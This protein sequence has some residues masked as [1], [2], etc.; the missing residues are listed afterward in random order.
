MNRGTTKALHNRSSLRRIGLAC[1]QL[2][3]G[4]YARMGF[5]A[6]GFV[7]P[8]K[9]PYLFHFPDGNASI[10]RMLVRSLIP[11]SAAGTTAEDI[12][13]ARVDYGK[14]DQSRSP[15]KIRLNSTVVR[16][17]HAGD[18]ASAKEVEVLYSAGKQFYSVRG[19]AVVMAC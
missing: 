15:V 2:D 6:K 9:N 13:T 18:P 12:V 5:T 8:R 3:P 1:L 4:P 10:A 14:L 7:A 16:A 19:K 11:Q 17:K